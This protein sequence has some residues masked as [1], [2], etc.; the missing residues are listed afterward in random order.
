MVY[1]F[2]TAVLTNFELFVYVEN[3][4]EKILYNVKHSSMIEAALQKWATPS[5]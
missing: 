1:F 4:N 3:I 2:R 5:N